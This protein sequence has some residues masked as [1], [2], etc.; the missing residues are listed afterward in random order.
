M[1]ESESLQYYKLIEMSR[2]QVEKK[3]K[4]NTDM[5][6]NG[7]VLTQFAA[8]IAYYTYIVIQSKKSGSI[9]AGGVR[10]DTDATASLKAAK[11]LKNEMLLLAS[12]V[13]VDKGFMFAAM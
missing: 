7:A 12:D 11:E 13:L 9:N 3:I 5:L 4:P 10:V 1:D 8:S 6:I 2:L